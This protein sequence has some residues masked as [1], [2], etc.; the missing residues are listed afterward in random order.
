LHYRYTWF[1]QSEGSVMVPGSER[2]NSE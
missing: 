1:Q 2:E